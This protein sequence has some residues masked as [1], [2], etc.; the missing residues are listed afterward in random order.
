MKS[1]KTKMVIKLGILILITCAGLGL[2]SYFTSNNALVSSVNTT[3]PQIA[4]QT[5]NSVEQKVN[6]DLNV[7]E[8]IVSQGEIT[9]P[10]NSYDTKLELFKDEVKRLGYIKM[11]IADLNGDVLF[12]DGKTSNVADREYFQKAK[13]GTK[14]ASDP[15]IGKTDGSIIIAYA[16][17][18]KSN[19]S[20]V[21]VLVCTQDSAELSKFTDNVKFGKTGNAFMVNKS[22]VVVAH[23]N[24]E[25]VKKMY[26]PIEEA[27]KDSALKGLGDIISKMTQGDSGKGEYYFQGVEKYVGYAPVNNTNWSIAV[28]ADKNDILSQL[29]SLNVSLVLAAIVFL[30]IGITFIYIISKGISDPI[31]RTSQHLGRLAEGDLSFEVSSKYINNQ[32][33]IGQM[34]RA[35]TEMKTSLS[36]MILSIKESSSSIESQSQNLS[37]VSEEMSSVSQNIALAINDMAQGTNTQS[38]DLLEATQLLDNF[39]ENLSV[40]VGEIGEIEENSKSIN[41]MA[42]DSSENMI[43]TTNS[44]NNID[45]SFNVFSDK[46]LK[47]IQSIKQINDITNVINSIADQTNLLALNAAIE[48]ARAGEAGKGFSVVADEIRKLAE[49]SK[50]SSESINNLIYDIERETNLIVD[51]TKEMSGE[52]NNQVKTINYSTESFK[53]IIDSINNIIPKIGYINSTAINLN[54]SKNSI[55]DKLN[56]ISAIAEETSASSEEI[57]AS[58]EELNASSEEVAASSN[59][60]SKMTRDMSEQINKFTI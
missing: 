27:K 2:I 17:P 55:L 34:A 46:I 13:S 54:T 15:I 29:T 25:L 1:I 21:G 41:T 44:I 33:E 18:V 57:S 24:V 38:D 12:T 4:V 45:N 49:Q 40:M 31:E 51:N 28:V 53:N 8:G 39:S 37:S 47:L 58:S 14:N 19:N 32:D 23:N 10:E 52:L 5:A 7:L 56:G 20:I 22:G 6:G 16:V 50:N 11:G 3:L 48:A 42:K 30:A 36:S 26:N 59:I 35:I 43:H 9:N 60:L